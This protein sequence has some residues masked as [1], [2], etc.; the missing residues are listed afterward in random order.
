MH[1]S[2]FNRGSRYAIPDRILAM[3]FA[4]R[5]ADLDTVVFPKLPGPREFSTI[6]RRVRRANGSGPK[7]IF[8]TPY[9]PRDLWGRE[10][11][12]VYSEN[13]DRIIV[14]D[15][16]FAEELFSGG[17][18][19]HVDVIPYVPP[20]VPIA[21]ADFPGVPGDPVKIGFLGRFEPQKNVTYLI[22]VLSNVKRQFELHLFGDGSQRQELEAFAAAKR[23]PAVFHGPV[24][25]GAKWQ[26]IESCHFFVNTSVS[27]GQCLVALEVLSR[28]RPFVATP[29]GAI[30]GILGDDRLGVL[31]PLDNAFG[32]AK[33]VDQVVEGFVKQ[34]WAPRQIAEAYRCRFPR[35][36][37]IERYLDILVG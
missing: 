7:L 32:A 19:R 34:R 8:V 31:L 35:Q 4:A 25:D 9:R 17:Y 6:V 26:A 36:E 10:I 3:R 16:S 15:A 29:V 11:P 27:E 12:A 18:R 5:L 1:L 22:D 30:P 37:S 14:Q 2:Q 23:V 13:I 20:A 33:R 28:G 24:F 21:L